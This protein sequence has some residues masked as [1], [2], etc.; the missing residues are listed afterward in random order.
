MIYLRMAGHLRE[1]YDAVMAMPMPVP[2]I[3]VVI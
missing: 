1:A 2:V 3:A